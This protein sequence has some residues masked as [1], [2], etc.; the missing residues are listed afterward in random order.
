MRKILSYGKYPCRNIDHN[1]EDLAAQVAANVTGIREIQSMINQF[2]IETVQAY[3]LHV[4]D[5]AE[6]CIR[7]AISKINKN[8][9]EL[10]NGEFI[11][12]FI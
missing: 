6:E 1:M 10:N 2:S 9:Y 7:I 4:Q 11:R 8:R 5:N 12:I 3:M